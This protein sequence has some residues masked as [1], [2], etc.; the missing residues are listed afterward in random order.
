MDAAVVRAL[1][2]NRIDRFTTAREFA[3]ALSQDDV[4]LSA[5]GP[6]ESARR[7]PSPLVIAAAILAVAG[8]VI[9]ILL[10]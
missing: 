4:A 10:R 1:A 2:P 3:Q 8:I 9:A 6:T 7:H 5:G